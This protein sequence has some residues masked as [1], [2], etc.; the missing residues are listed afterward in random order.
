MS[1]PTCKGNMFI[2]LCKSII[3][4]NVTRNSHA[5]IYSLHSFVSCNMLCTRITDQGQTLTRA[6]KQVIHGRGSRQIS[7]FTHTVH[8]ITINTLTNK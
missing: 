4:I 8:I 7:L 2:A 1:V 6:K 5:L 3:C